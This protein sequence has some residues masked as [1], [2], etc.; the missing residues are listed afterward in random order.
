[1]KKNNYQ[2]TMYACFIG[3]IVQAIVNNFLPLLFVTFQKTYSIPLTQ[4]TLLI[5]LNF[6][7][8]LVIDMLS[9]GFVDKIG[10]RAS[11]IIAHVC[12]AAGLVLLTVL[13]GA[14]PDP[15]AGILIAVFIY[16]IGGGLIEVLISP[17]LEA[18]PTDNKEKAMSLLHSFYCWGQLGTVAI[19]TLFLFAFGTG[20][21]PVL[22]CLWAI[23]PA[24]GIA[25]FAGAPMPRI[26]PEGTATM[27]FADLSKKPVFYLM[28]LM[29]LCAGAAEQGM[30]QWASAFAESGLGVT[31]V[32]GDL[33]GPAAFALMMGLSRTIYGV[34]GH[35][36][37]LTAFIASSSVLCVAMYLTAALTTAPVL[38]L[39]ACALTGFSVGIMWPGTFSM[40]ADAMPG[41][42]TLMF[43]LL[44]VA[45]DLGCAGGPAVVGLVASANGDSL[46]TGL[47]F[48]SMFALV[49]LACVVAA[50]K[51]VVGEREPLH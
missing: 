13:P 1:M 43:A 46:K 15:F 51:T 9:A 48:G 11:A 26:V 24:I 50:R 41:G 17:I 42:G 36:L 25:M 6:G 34:L 20:S 23:V 22:A 21:W 28:F 4:I 29:M 5:T 8:Q 19:S 12:S 35:R 38:G 32:I 18:C 30:S 16:A 47:L 44:A 7:I 2:L 37:D 49:L 10:Y 3:Y 33:A 39:L 14:F 40:A 31:K 27:R 45:G